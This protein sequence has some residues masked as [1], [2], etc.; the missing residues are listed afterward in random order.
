MSTKQ[1]CPY[2]TWPVK[3]GEPHTFCDARL[4]EIQQ[5]K[6]DEEKAWKEYQQQLDS[7][8][9]I[10]WEEHRLRQQAEAADAYEQETCPCGHRHDQHYMDD[11][12]CEARHC[13]CPQFGEP[14]EN[15]ETFTSTNLDG[16]T[17]HE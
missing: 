15:W 11:G 10:A 13:D 17:I 3:P 9:D 6:V 2:C 12:S 16:Y 5:A 1:I 7:E 8:V 4:A 14:T